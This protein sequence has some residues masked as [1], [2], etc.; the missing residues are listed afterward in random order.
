MFKKIIWFVG[1]TVT[2][3]IAQQRF[4][5][6][7]KWLLLLIYFHSFVSICKAVEKELLIVQL[8]CHFLLGCTLPFILQ[9]IH[10][11]DSKSTRWF[12]IVKE[13]VVGSVVLSFYCFLERCRDSENLLWKS[14]IV[15]QAI[16][17]VSQQRWKKVIW[18]RK[19]DR[20]G[21]W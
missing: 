8:V 5:G 10:S 14:H 19:H 17:S 1:W 20:N 7:V 11:S 4:A 15:N 21:A 13:P 3:A 9:V 16:R 18:A 2:Y 12:R 6:P